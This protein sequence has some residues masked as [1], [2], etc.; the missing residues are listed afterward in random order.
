MNKYFNFLLCLFLSLL[1]TLCVTVLIFWGIFSHDIYTEHDFLSTVIR[2]TTSKEYIEDCVTDYIQRKDYQGLKLWSKSSGVEYQV[3]NHSG[4]PLVTSENYYNY[5]RA[6]FLLDIPI[7][8]NTG[9]KEIYSAHIV[10]TPSSIYEKNTFL[11]HLKNVF[12]NNPSLLIIFFLMFFC[13]LFLCLRVLIRYATPVF[14]L[15]FTTFYILVIDCAVIFL[16]GKQEYTKLFLFFFA[17]K[18][19]FLLIALCYL[20]FLGKIRKTIQTIGKEAS[21]GEPEKSFLPLSLRPFMTD[22]R[23]ASESIQDAVNERMKSE[24]LK[25]EL[26][27]N[28]SHD[29]KTPLTSIINFSDLIA[30]EKTENATITEYANHLHD[31]SLRLKKLL[32]ALIEASKASCGVVDI[33][34][35]PC[36][37][38]T[39][40]EQCIVEYE[41]KLRAGQIELI[42]L[43]SEEELEI[44]ADTN[45]LCRIFDNLLT[46]I[47]RY[48]LPGSR[49]YLETKV[50]EEKVSIIF[51]N[52]SKEPCNLSQEELTER[53]VRGDASRHSEGH[54]LGLSIVK[55]LMDLM[56]GELMINAKY[57]IFEVTLSFPRLI[58][59]P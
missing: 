29:I 21:D 2:D 23:H 1:T 37:I 15:C 59:F 55:S 58:A 8:L 53:F 9:E 39:I 49:A 46:N 17:E 25:T 18:T 22:A 6:E 43:P 7:S 30:K 52:V 5:D 11:H 35:V 56:K 16:F 51:R 12:V 45:A 57:D 3:I 31:Q 36:N 28:V 33:H 44:S 38:R 19:V 42:T 47:S 4:R 14:K 20:R 48:A 27:S 50:N 34:P 24:R 54:G 26:I 41:D 40:L 13:I 32:E 10:K